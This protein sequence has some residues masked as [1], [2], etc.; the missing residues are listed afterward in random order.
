MRVTAI[1][2]KRPWH[3]STGLYYGFLMYVIN[4]PIDVRVAKE[5]KR[6]I[7]ED[8]FMLLKKNCCKTWK[9]SSPN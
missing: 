4:L 1:D 5:E 6:V 8:C 9:N 2:H 3:S 7:E